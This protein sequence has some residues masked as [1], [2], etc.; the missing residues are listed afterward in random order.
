MPIVI[1][2]SAGLVF[3]LAAI[4]ANRRWATVLVVAPILGWF[5][6]LVIAIDDGLTS[7]Q[8][9]GLALGLLGILLGLAVGQVFDKR[10]HGAVRRKRR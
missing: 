9:N 5:V 4:L 10:D 8:A 3:G 1:G 6:L 7:E 2:L